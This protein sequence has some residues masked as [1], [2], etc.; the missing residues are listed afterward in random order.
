MSIGDQFRAIYVMLQISPNND[1]YNFLLTCIDCFSR[2]A[3]VIHNSEKKDW[4]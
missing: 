2:Y 1:N 3:W 4:Y